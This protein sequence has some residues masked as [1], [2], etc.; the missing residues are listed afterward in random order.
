MTNK[1]FNNKEIREPVSHYICR[2]N[3]FGPIESRVLE[4]QKW[5]NLFTGKV[6]PR[7]IISQELGRK[8]DLKYI[9]GALTETI[10]GSTKFRWM[11]KWI[12]SYIPLL[13][14]DWITTNLKETGNHISTLYE[15]KL[16][17]DEHIFKYSDGMDIKLTYEYD[18]YGIFSNPTD[19]DILVKLNFIRDYITFNSNRLWTIPVVVTIKNIKGEVI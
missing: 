1:L 8:D 12:E 4:H 19:K 2:E 5:V 16:I 13:Y 9:K 11:S 17:L 6:D 18:G 15:T 7:I 14:N 10:N 3:P